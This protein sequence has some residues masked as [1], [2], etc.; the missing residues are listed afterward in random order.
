MNAIASENDLVQSTPLITYYHNEAGAVFTQTISAET[1]INLFGTGKH[2]RLLFWKI[3]S[4]MK[5]FMNSFMKI[6]R[7]IRWAHISRNCEIFIIY[8]FDT[9]RI[10]T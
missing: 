1:A 2:F 10:L 9:Y 6:Y 4:S 5:T 3:C 7:Q 8:L